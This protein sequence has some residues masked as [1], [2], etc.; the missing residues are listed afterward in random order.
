M[1][2]TALICGTI[3]LVTYGV[4]GTVWDA[5]WYLAPLLAVGVMTW[6]TAYSERIKG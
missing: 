3:L 4:L 2:P 6:L 1:K 5:G